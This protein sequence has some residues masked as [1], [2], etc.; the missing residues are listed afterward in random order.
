EGIPAAVEDLR[1]Q[2]LQLL[3]CAERI[4]VELFSAGTHPFTNWGDQVMSD[5]GSYREIIKRT[6]YWGRQMIIWGIHVHV[7]VGGRDRVWPIINAVMTQYPHVL[8]LSASSPAWEGL[9]TGY[10]SNRTL[11]YQ[12]LP[13]AGMPYQ[14]ADWDE[15]EAFNVDQDR[16]GVI[17][18]TGSMHFDVRPSKY[19][20]VEVRFADAT[21]EVWEVGAIAAFIHCLVVHYEREW[22]AGRALRTLQHWHG[23]GNKWRAAREG[24][25]ALSST[26][27]DAAETWVTEETAGPLA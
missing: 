12:Q 4:G 3:D 20:T 27:R 2:L 15:W 13:T 22:Q 23:G 17:N 19:G 24:T 10:A 18:H 9:D 16:S 1:E 26:D 7:G 5:K 6:Q 14:F 8:A 21:M 11:L 25:E